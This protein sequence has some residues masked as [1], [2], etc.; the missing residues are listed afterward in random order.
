MFYI[1]TVCNCGVG[2]SAFSRKLVSDAVEEL[3]YNKS[4]V[5][6]ECTEII[7]VKG[8]K[9]DVIVTTKVLAKRMP[10]PGGKLRA[11]IGVKSLVKDKDGMK[12]SLKPILD[13]AHE[14]GL[15]RLL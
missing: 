13:Q 12:E 1:V 3:G 6:V 14:E 4:D 9:P 11:V 8:L 7:G 2:T 10:Q 15:I 5:K